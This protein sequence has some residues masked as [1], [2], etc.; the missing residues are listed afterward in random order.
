MGLQLGAAVTPPLV[1][2][3]MLD[4]GWQRALLWIAVPA[5]GLIGLWARYARNTPREHP[6]VSAVELAE[7]GDHRGG[8]SDASISLERLVRVIADRD[9]LLLAVSYLCMN[10]V[11]Y[12]LANWVFLYLIQERHFSVLE[13]G[14]LAT[15]PPLAAAL[16]SGLGGVLAVG[17]CRR[18]GI[19]WGFRAVPLVALPASGLLLFA[20][21]HAG[22]AYIA[23]AALALCYGSV[24]LT[25]ASYWSAAM[26]VGRRDTMA[27][28]GLMNTGGNLGGI[29][30]I[31]IVAYLSQHQ[32]WN[33]A[34]FVGIGFA[35][36][37]A[38]AWLGIDAQRAPGRTTGK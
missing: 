20:A 12:L 31:P 6:D 26:T 10:Y 8:E 13:S 32:A 25:E 2:A 37:S 33:A 16:G 22:S 4:L 34:F 7:I 28:C 24:E 23:V 17:Q 3:L 36:A 29:V 30:G 35:L 5:L 11:F 14:W 9:V 15:I 1:V 18:H 27:A 19:R 21:V 38:L